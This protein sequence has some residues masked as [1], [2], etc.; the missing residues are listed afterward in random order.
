[1]RE[2][3]WHE[4]VEA[5][6]R[7]TY[8]KFYLSQQRV[9]NKRFNAFILI[10]SASGVLGWGVWKIF[11]FATSI[12]VTG[13]SLIKLIGTELLPNDKVFEKSEK[14]IDFYFDYFNQIEN[15]WYDHYNY[16]IDDNE[17]QCRFYNIVA[18]EKEINKIVNE[19]IRK[20]NKEFLT[21]SE[22]ETDKYFEKVF[23]VK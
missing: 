7:S 22:E 19:I 11:P 16:I 1:M 15:L 21:K 17:A 9:I 6:L 12:V 4:M 10:F 5:K 8:A 13:M 14:I 3:I 2:R 23:N 20:P 18:T